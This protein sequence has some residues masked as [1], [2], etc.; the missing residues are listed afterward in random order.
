MPGA[1]VQFIREFAGIKEFLLTTNGLR[2]LLIPRRLG[3]IAALMVHYNVG[4]RNEAVGHT[5]STHF[6][7]HL[8]FKGSKNF[9][10]KTCPIDKIFART[11]AIYN[12]NTGNDR[13]A[14][15]EVVV[16]EHLP[17]FM[18]IE[19]DRMRGAS[20]TDQDR[21]DEMT[22]VRNELEIVE[23]DSDSVLCWHLL[24][25]TAIL[26]HPYHHPTIGY[27]ADVEGVATSRIREFYD[28]FYHPNN[29]VVAVAG[30]F[31]E[32][33][34]LGMIVQYFGEIPRS[35]R[36]IPQVYTIEP[37][38]HGERRVVLKRPGQNGT[39]VLGWVVP[40]MTHEDYASLD[41]LNYILSGGSGGLLTKKFVNTG[42]VQSANCFLEPLRDSYP[43]IIAVKLLENRGHRNIERQI[44]AYLE[45]LQN[46]INEDHVERARRL[47]LA[48]ATYRDDD[49]ISL[50]MDIS[51]A[52]GAGSWDLNA[53]LHERQEK[54][55][56]D[57]VCTVMR[58][59]LIPD[60]ITVGWFVPERQRRGA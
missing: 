2:I 17:T 12:A 22:V 6:L 20:F 25:G 27:R 3:K 14:Y 15:Y 49:M 7:E 16:P 31:K 40:G 43:F 5:G 8:N 60:N 41:L 29:A 58:K 42:L 30:N 24:V 47:T 37:P 21:Q 13:T 34:V 23:S 39:L 4:S 18:A 48:G 51:D 54:L 19:A 32:R 59:Y 55:T 46:E 38:Q 10:G 26:E 44:R 28:T 9:P 33:E 35:A 36:S 56:S 53:R 1:N 50:M 57:D 52:E 45:E 11:G